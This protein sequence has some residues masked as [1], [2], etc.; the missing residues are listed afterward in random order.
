[1]D[2]SSIKITDLIF[3]YIDQFK[4]LFYPD[5]WSKIFSDYSRNEIFTLIYL[6]RNPHANMSEVAAYINV[7]LNTATGVVSRMEKKGLVLRERNEQ[8]K[9]IVTLCLTEIGEHFVRCEIE[10]IEHIYEKVAKEL[11]PEELTTI[12]KAI[13]RIFDILKSDRT[14]EKTSSKKQVKRITIE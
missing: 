7:P 3:Q 14:K 2:P 6:Y 10:E 8:D 9:R 4:F 12:M 1:M 5:Q 11:T 13:D